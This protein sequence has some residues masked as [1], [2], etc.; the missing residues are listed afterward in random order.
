MDRLRNN[1]YF[2][3]INFKVKIFLCSTMIF[4]FT[5]G[6]F[7]R[8]KVFMVLAFCQQILKLGYKISI[9][10]KSEFPGLLKNVLTCNPRWSEP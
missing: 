1:D 7:V 8:V 3:L 2:I 6:V 4:L 10:S 9:F 5:F